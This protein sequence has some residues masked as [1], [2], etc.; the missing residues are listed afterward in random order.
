MARL[1]LEYKKEVL[2]DYPFRR[3][4]I[5]IGR[6]KDN[7]IVLD[8]PEVSGYHARI[9]KKGSAF[10][11][12]DLQSTNGTFVN[13]KHVISKRLAH[14]DKITIGDHTLLFVGTEKAK[15]EAEQE[16]VPFDKTIIIGSTA[17]QRDLLPKPKAERR[18]PQPQELEVSRPYKRITPIFITVIIGVAAGWILLSHGPFLIKKIFERSTPTGTIRDTSKMSDRQ[19]INTPADRPAAMTRRI[20]ERTSPFP[21]SSGERKASESQSRVYLDEQTLSEGID[22]SLFKIDGIVW[23]SDPKQSFAVINGSIVRVGGSIEGM[24]VADIGNDYVILE[25]PDGDTK[26]RLTYR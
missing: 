8:N 15:L 10:I 18:E 20:P 21:T 9:D 24:K 3:V 22:E 13:N 4:S 26:V 5:T 12:T 17:R 6:H 11:L 23:S 25:S 16:E 7:T 2:K 1:I 14:G 19:P